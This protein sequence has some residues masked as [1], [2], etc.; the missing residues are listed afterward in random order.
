[1]VTMKTMIIMVMKIVITIKLLKQ[2]S[3]LVRTGTEPVAAGFVMKSES[4]KLL[5]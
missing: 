2:V 1:M 4:R 5:I 3:E